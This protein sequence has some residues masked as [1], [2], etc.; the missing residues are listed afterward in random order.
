MLT[1]AIAVPYVLFVWWF[2]T[3]A[4]LLLVGASTQHDG[5]LKGGSLAL[6]AAALAGIAASGRDSGPSGAYCAFTCAILLWG[7]VE[8]SLLA[9]W[10]TGPRPQACPR[11]CA[12]ADR[13]WYA[14]QAIAYHELLLIGT[15]ALVFFVTTGLPNRV[16]WWTFGALFA[17]RESAKLNLFLGVRTLNE[18]ML[19]PRVKFIGSYFARGPINGLFP[20][21][22]SLVTAAAAVLSV[23]AVAVI[24]PFD[25]L[26]LSLLAALVALGALEHWFMVMPIP[27]ARLWRW[28][29][30]AAASGMAEP[31]VPSEAVSRPSLALI[32]GGAVAEKLPVP[33]RHAALSARE[34]LEEQ[35]RQEY[36]E[37]N[38]T[39]EHAVNLQAK[40]TA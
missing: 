39:H 14:L 12:P 40:G 32:V 36:R 22:V 28:S 23:A 29:I 20:L 18:E 19:P 3:G 33:V 8:I 7:A 2:S 38:N 1:L 16:G 4:V 34:R 24:S 15:A 26:G 37:T 17:M 6:F 10:I 13:I 9:G 35:Y 31:A 11:N 5:W 30:P 21:S 27:A 25:R